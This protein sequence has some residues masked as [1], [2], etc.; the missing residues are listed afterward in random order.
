MK[1]QSPTR[2]EEEIKKLREDKEGAKKDAA[3]TDHGK[4]GDDEG[5]DAPKR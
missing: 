3:K 5:K 1:K 2:E 4:L